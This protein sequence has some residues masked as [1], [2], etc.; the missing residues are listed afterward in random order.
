MSGQQPEM[1][2]DPVPT[3]GARPRKIVMQLQPDEATDQGTRVF[4]KVMA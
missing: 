1:A 3:E 4:G 2:S